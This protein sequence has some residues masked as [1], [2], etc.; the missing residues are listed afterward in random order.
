MARKSKALRGYATFITKVREYAK[1]KP[2]V[3]AIKLA[4]EYCLKKGML[5]DYFKENAQEVIKMIKLEYSFKDELKFARKEGKAE[6]REEGKAEGQ[7]YILELMAQGL[8][9][10]E[11]KKKIEKAS[12]KKP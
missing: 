11:I 9:Y 4:V 2:L 12:K 7:N 5:T 1:T 8:S 6:G 10:E 3:E